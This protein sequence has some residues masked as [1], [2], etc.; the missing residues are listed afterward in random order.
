MSLPHNQFSITKQNPISS[1]YFNDVSVLQQE[2]CLDLPEL[3]VS[4]SYESTTSKIS[5]KH[6]I[7]EKAV[8]LEHPYT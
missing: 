3:V 2:V 6:E 7:K 5:W 8:L 4:D 1:T